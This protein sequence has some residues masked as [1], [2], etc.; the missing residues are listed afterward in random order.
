MDLGL[1]ELSNIFIA[2]TIVK[3]IITKKHNQYS[4]Q[5]LTKKYIY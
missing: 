1:K 5:N 2:D 4:K 3:R